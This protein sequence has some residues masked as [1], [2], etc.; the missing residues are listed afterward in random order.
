M[1]KPPHQREDP[2]TR[3]CHSFAPALAKKPWCGRPSMH[4]SCTGRP[5][6]SEVLEEFHARP[7]ARQ[8]PASTGAQISE[9]S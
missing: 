8:C 1:C 6:M 3:C 2:R 9:A 4:R 5:C 7:A